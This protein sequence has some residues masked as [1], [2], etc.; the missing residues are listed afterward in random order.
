M[1]NKIL[2]IGTLFTIAFAAFLF[3]PDDQQAPAV[4]EVEA[5]DG[6]EVVMYKSPTC[7]CCAKWAVHMNAN[8]FAVEE[9]PTEELYQIKEENGIT[10]Q[11]AS[12]HTALVG[13]YVVE[14][15]VPAEDVKRLLAEKPDAIGITV[16]GMP[17]GSPGM[18][19]EGREADNYDVLLI[20]KDGST[21]VWA[22]H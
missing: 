11:L 7:G 13:G 6:I 22:S 18:E 21:S 20:N 15:H 1:N 19:V 9:R 12:C 10:R 16:P 3:W 4:V 8:D 2:V 5:G 14:G 17:I